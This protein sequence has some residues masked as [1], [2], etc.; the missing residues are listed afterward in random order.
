MNGAGSDTTEHVRRPEKSAN[1]L[2][3]DL[4]YVVTEREVSPSKIK[5]PELERGNEIWAMCDLFAGLLFRRLILMDEY[6]N[7]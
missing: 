7:T 2:T 5:K 4:A 1:T 6:N 3:L